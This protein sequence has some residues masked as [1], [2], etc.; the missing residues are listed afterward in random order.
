MQVLGAWLSRSMLAGV[1]VALEVHTALNDTPQ[2]Q[3]LG[4]FT[5]L[6]ELGF[7]VHFGQVLP[8]V[9]QPWSSRFTC[10]SA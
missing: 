4:E 5:L 1:E 9:S 3:V 8:I 7:Y 6:H 10:C 2:A